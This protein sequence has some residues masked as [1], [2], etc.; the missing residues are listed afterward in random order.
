MI[1][2][3]LEQTSFRIGI[4]AHGCYLIQVLEALKTFKMSHRAE[5]QLA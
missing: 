5:L 2:D 4:A 1:G 3:N